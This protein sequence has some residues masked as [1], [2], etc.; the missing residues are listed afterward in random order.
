MVNLSPEHP[1]KEQQ[2]PEIPSPDRTVFQIVT[3]EINKI[4][5]L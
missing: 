3:R 5:N 4:F 2:G 1:D